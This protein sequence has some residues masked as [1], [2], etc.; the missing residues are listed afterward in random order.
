MCSSRQ[1]KNNDCGALLLRAMRYFNSMNPQ[2][3]EGESEK[4]ESLNIPREE[5]IA[6]PPLG[7]ELMCVAANNGM[8]YL[9]VVVCMCFFAILIRRNITTQT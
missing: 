7:L 1:E 8:R 5:L 3:R 2:I 9:S 6:G 4:I